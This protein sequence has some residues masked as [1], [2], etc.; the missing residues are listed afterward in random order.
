MNLDEKISKTKSH[1][2]VTVAAEIN[3]LPA[4]SVATQQSLVYTRGGMP[5]RLHIF[6][7]PHL[8]GI[9]LPTPVI[10]LKPQAKRPHIDNIVWWQ[11]SKAS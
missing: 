1:Y 6:S 9:K 2:R 11:T 4:G 5:L 8:S 7:G 3:T 10:N